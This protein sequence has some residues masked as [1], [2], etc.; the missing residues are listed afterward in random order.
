MDL[1]PAHACVQSTGFRQFQ[2]IGEELWSL[3]FVCPHWDPLSPLASGHEVY[4]RILFTSDHR[5]S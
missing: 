5:V 4:M 3:V 1:A 2:S